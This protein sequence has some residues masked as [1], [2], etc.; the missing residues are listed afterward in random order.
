MGPGVRSDASLGGHLEVA[1]RLGLQFVDRYWSD[2]ALV[3][4]VRELARTLGVGRY[5]TVREFQSNGLYGPYQLLLNGEEVAGAAANLGLQR[6]VPRRWRAD[7]LRSEVRRLARDLGT[8]RYPT[9]K[10]FSEHGLGGVY[11]AIDRQPG[12]HVKF[13][14]DCAMPRATP[15]GQWMNREQLFGEPSRRS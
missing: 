15:R 1:E 13:A 4:A 8:E 14:A 6:V 7:E 3:Q 11:Q 2:D 12:G 9:L 5:P 10:Q